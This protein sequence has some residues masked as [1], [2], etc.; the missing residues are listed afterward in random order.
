MLCFTTATVW[1]RSTTYYELTACYALQISCGNLE[2]FSIAAVKNSYLLI[3]ALPIEAELHKRHLSLLHNIMVTSNETI[4][5]LTKRQ[6]AINL[7]NSL[8][9]YHRVQDILDL[10]QQPSLR[11][12]QQG[13]PSKEQWKF[14]VKQAV[15]TYWSEKLKTESNE[16]STL[17]FLNKDILRIGQT[18]PIWSTLESTVSD[19]RKGITKGRMLAGTYLLQTSQHKFSRSTISAACKCCGLNDEDLPHMLLEC[20]ALLNQRKLFYPRIKHN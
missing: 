13:I 9:Y 17:T 2:T 16:K 8:S 6:I 1:T 11:N 14:T 19:V 3:G 12:L 5:E 4:T 7:D 20:P 15:N 10:Y 18:H